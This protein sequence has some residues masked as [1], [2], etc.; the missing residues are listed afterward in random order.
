MIALL[1]VN[2]GVSG[3]H[4]GNNTVTQF[5]Y[6]YKRFTQFLGMFYQASANTSIYSFQL[7]STFRTEEV[8]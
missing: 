2:E 6:T 5:S 1:V 8:K 3:F 7:Y 4:L